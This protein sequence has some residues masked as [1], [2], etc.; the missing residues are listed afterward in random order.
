MKLAEK[1]RHAPPPRLDGP[2]QAVAEEVGRWTDVRARTHWRLG[3]ER[4]VDGADFYLGE[5]E[6]GHLHLD[7]EA[8]VALPREVVTALVRAGL[9]EPLPWSRSFVVFGVA[10]AADRAHAL[11][12]FQLSYAR[13]RGASVA[14]LVEQVHARAGA[15]PAERAPALR[16]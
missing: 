1:G 14:E 5:E 4:Q 6:L 15:V 11:W 12:L 8:H 13:R 3:D 2:A 10:R 7:G 9:G 16:A